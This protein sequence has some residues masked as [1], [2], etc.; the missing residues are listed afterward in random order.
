M[1]RVGRSLV[2]VGV[3]LTVAGCGPLP[4]DEDSAAQVATEFRSAVQQGDGARACR[5]LAPA[6]VA[7]V[8]EAVGKP[9][10][11]A[12]IGEQVPVSGDVRHVDAFGQS[13]RVVFCDDTLFLSS[14]GQGCRVMAAVCAARDGRPYDC[15]VKGG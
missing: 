11:E 12:I 10:A 8:A 13:A 5:L 2:A 6:A 15:A 9:C 3:A 14:F 4:P 1:R 7:E